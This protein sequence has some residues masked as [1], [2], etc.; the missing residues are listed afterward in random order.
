MEGTKC[1]KNVTDKVPYSILQVDVPQSG[2]GF[3]TMSIIIMVECRWVGTPLFGGLG[4]LC[5][6]RCSHF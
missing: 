5:L 1:R 3:T 2:L 4:L 6:E